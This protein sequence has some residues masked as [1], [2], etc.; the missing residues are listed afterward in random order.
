MVAAHD[1]ESV[2]PDGADRA[3]E[4]RGARLLK[5]QERDSEDSRL[6]HQLLELGLAQMLDVEVAEAHAVARFEQRRGYIQG[7]ERW[8][9]RSILR[10]ARAVV[11]F[12]ECRVEQCHVVSSVFARDEGREMVT[13]GRLPRG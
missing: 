13:P 4:V 9:L 10:P 6:S 3:N 1:D 2:G 7:A 5:G 11:V 8:Y 12:A